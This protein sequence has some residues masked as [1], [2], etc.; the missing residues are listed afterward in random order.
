MYTVKKLAEFSGVSIRTLHFYDEI[1]L[2]K[3]AY[4]GSNGYRYYKEEHLL[5]LQQILFFRQLGLSLTEIQKV[6]ACDDFNKIETL[7]SHKQALQQQQENTSK[8]IQT[9]DKTIA[10]LEGKQKMQE[11]AMF[12]GFEATN[13]AKYNEIA[14]AEIGDLAQTLIERRNQRI[15]HWQEHDWENLKQAA[16]DISLKLVELMQTRTPPSADVVQD[17]MEHLYEKMEV[18]Y[19]PNKTE[20]LAICQLNCEHP[21]FRKQFDYYHETLAEYVLE[22]AKIFAERNL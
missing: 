17:V 12:D 2:L 1:G 20:Y 11:K 15:G 16:H 22:A 8:L 4:Y 19:V 13:Q 14:I 6:V 21:E 5:M 18:M 10:H 9:I 3:P 7:K